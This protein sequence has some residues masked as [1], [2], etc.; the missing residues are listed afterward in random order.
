MKYL[1]YLVLLFLMGCVIEKE[2]LK[3]DFDEKLEEGIVV[4]YCIYKW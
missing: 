3:S 4:Q 2:Q 1:V